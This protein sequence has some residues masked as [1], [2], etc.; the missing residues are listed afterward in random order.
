MSAAE[1][2]FQQTEEKLTVVLAQTGDR[3]AFRNLVDLYD[4]R[5]FYFVRKVVGDTDDALDVLQSVWLQVHRKLAGL[6]SP[7][8]FRVWIYR[9][10]HSKAIDAL[11]KLKKQPIA[12]DDVESMEPVAGQNDDENELFD[13]AELVH[14]ALE[15]L[16]VDHRRVLTLRFL[17]DMTIDEIA[18]VTDQ[19]SGTVKSRIHY[20]K[21]SLRRRIKELLDD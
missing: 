17:E 7:N 10:A 11:R 13:N 20:A 8:A 14:V 19:A 15:D 21:R 18:E 4:K 2:N 3:E 9:I 16:S 6:S 1:T 12:V 5:L